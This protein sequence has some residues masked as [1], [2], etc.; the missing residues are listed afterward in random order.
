[1]R[2]LALLGLLSLAAAPQDQVKLELKA[3]KGDKVTVT[4]SKDMS[5]SFTVSANGQEQILENSEKGAEKYSDEVVAT[6]ETGWPIEVKRSITEWWDEEKRPQGVEPVKTVSP[7]EGKTVTLKLSGDKTTVEGADKVDAKWIKSMK[8]KKNLFV[9]SLPSKPVAKGA[10]W[11][12][13]GDELIKDFDED[14]DAENPLKMKKGSATGTLKDIAGDVATVTYD[15][16]MEGDMYGGVKV[17]LKML[18]TVQIDTA[19]T[20]IL[21]MNGEGTMDLDGEV[22][23]QGFTMKGTMRLKNS[24]TFS[25]P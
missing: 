12:V 25:Y 9:R 10:T 17:T 7:L 8:L 4:E 14:R 18:V 2:F 23:E 13:P 16:E 19:K 5:G 22:T 15:I 3:K 20:R 21:S 1:M 11:S 24:A 6:D